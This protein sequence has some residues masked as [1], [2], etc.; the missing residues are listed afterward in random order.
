MKAIVCTGYGAP[1]VL[2]LRELEKPTPK[3][4]EVRIKI[5]ATAV[6]SSDCLVRSFNF[7]GPISVPVRLVLGITR[8]RR[9]VLGLV[10]AGEID[11]VGTSV[12]SFKVGDRVFGFEGFAFGAVSYTHLTLPTIC[13]V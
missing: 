4:A 9:A 3:P 6:T 2:Q 7:H 5:H 8:P 13:S 12:R 1:D 11:S 10:L